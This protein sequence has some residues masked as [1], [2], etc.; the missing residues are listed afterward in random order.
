MGEYF[1]FLKTAEADVE[2]WKCMAYV[3]EH[4]EVSFASFYSLRAHQNGNRRDGVPLCQSRQ[5]RDVSAACSDGDTSDSVYTSCV[6][7]CMY[8]ACTCT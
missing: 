3:C 7:V 8:R 1:K 4:C 6:C 2:A 5:T